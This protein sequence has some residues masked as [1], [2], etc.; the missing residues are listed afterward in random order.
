MHCRHIARLIKKDD[1]DDDDD[2][3]STN[4]VKRITNFTVVM[5][6]VVM[7]DPLDRG[8]S[9]TRR[10]GLCESVGKLYES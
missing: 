3:G 7:V 10:S 4:N 6:V 8:R 9:R 5:V 2:D 1:D